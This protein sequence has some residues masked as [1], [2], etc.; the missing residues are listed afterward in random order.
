MKPYTGIQTV[1]IYSQE[2]DK[3]MTPSF[4]VGW[5]CC[6]SLFN[7]WSGG[8][9]F[10]YPVDWTTKEIAD[11]VEE[12]VKI[13][14]S[15]GAN[16]EFIKRAPGKDF[17]QHAKNINM[18]Y[19]RSISQ[20]AEPGDDLITPESDWFVFYVKH[21]TKLIN[22]FSFCLIRSWFSSHTRG[23]I[24]DMFE[25][26]K[27][28]PDVD[29]FTCFQLAHLAPPNM[30]GYGK[31]FIAGIPVL[32]T[33]SVFQTRLNANGALNPCFNVRKVDSGQWSSLFTKLHKLYE[34]GKYE[35]LLKEVA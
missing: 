2:G 20:G 33:L 19:M 13:L 16:I 9:Y 27:K 24:P 17:W 6:G 7:T 10:A 26:K 34:S 1:G 32:T 21:S 11:R 12:V 15:F 28:L 8:R 29:Y 14:N 3:N 35:E 5:G 18:Q 25:L 4:S 23:L 31:G 22:Y 30:Y